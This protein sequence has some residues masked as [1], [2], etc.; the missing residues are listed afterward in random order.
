MNKLQ[1]QWKKK[2]EDAWNSGKY[3]EDQFGDLKD[4]MTDYLPQEEAD[5]VLNNLDI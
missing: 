4:K 2:L 3:S 5:E 1:L